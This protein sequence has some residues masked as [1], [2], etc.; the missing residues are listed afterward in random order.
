MS[1]L[2]VNEN[3]I[4]CERADVHL[5]PWRPVDRA[6]ISHGHADHARWGHKKYLCTHSARPVIEYRLPQAKVQSLAYGEKVTINGVQFSFHPAG[7]VLG[8]AQIR[9]AYKDE[10][11]VF[12]GDFKTQKDP[13]AE[14]FEVVPCGHLI[15]ECTFGLPVFRWPDEKDLKEE[16]NAWWA[17]CQEQSVMPVIGSYS[18][19]KAQRVIAMLD[20][21]IGPILTHGAVE[22]TNE[23]M[24]KQGISLPET[25]RVEGRS[26]AE[27]QRDGIVICPPSAMRSAWMKKFRPYKTAMASGWMASRGN[28]RR[29]NV[30]RGFLISDHADWDGLQ[31]IVTESGAE[32]VLTT[33]GYSHVFAR[34]LQ[35]EMDVKSRELKTEYGS[36]DE[37]SVNEK[38]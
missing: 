5:D 36:E 26:I 25:T 13:I 28:R 30:D 7:H 37:D 19:G 34:Y 15:M 22:N 9:A 23:V 10:V 3:G 17:D 8:S 2:T 16:I 20:K 1:L 29:R 31:F 4:Y 21:S 12:T 35:E 27:A 6:L 32:E 11:W 24:R 14:D 33:H 18:L 38:V